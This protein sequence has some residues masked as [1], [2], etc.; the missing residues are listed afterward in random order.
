[1]NSTEE[2][3]RQMSQLPVILE[4]FN[5]LSQYIGHLEQGVMAISTENYSTQLL[6][7]AIIDSLVEKGLFTKEEVNEMLEEKVNK[8]VKERLDK[9]NQ[10][11]QEAVEKAQQ[12]PII[13]TPEEP[14]EEP[15]DNSNVV[16]ASER[17]GKEKDGS[18]IK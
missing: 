13:E 6:Q 15:E 1:M 2:F 14:E 10:Q 5:L 11:M 9:I 4:K 12:Q 18:K 8:P 7:K 16:L 17:F 3:M